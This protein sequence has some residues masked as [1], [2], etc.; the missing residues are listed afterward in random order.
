MGKGIPIE[1]HSSIFEPF[2]TTKISESGS[3]FW[4]YNTKI[5]IEDHNGMIGFSTEE[6]IV[7]HSISLFQLNTMRVTRCQKI[8]KHAKRA[9]RTFVKNRKN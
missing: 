7:L 5:F 9:S 4:L 2:V 8:S 3:G 1:L 6:G